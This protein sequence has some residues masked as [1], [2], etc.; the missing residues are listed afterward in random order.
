SLTGTVS[1]GVFFLNLPPAPILFNGVPLLPLS[2]LFQ[3][4]ASIGLAYLNPNAI[5]PGNYLPPSGVLTPNNVV[6]GSV[7]SSLVTG[8]GIS[9]DGGSESVAGA[10][11]GG[12]GK[13]SGEGAPTR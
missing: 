1:N 4:G 13:E 5:V 6:S 7:T 11:S 2:T 3:P 8:S 10:P 12:E 9:I